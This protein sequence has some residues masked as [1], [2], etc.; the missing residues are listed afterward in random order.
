MSTVQGAAVCDEDDREEG[1]L[2]RSKSAVMQVDL[3]TT[4]SPVEKAVKQVR[5]AL[6]ATTTHL[7]APRH[8][9]E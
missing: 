5:T 9:G 2:T 8:L 1:R 6:A 4:N 3:S 7:E